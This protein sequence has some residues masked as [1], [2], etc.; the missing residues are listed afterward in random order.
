MEILKI[1]TTIIRKKTI[2]YLNCNG[3][4]LFNK[5]ECFCLSP[6][7]ILASGSKIFC[8]TNFRN[9]NFVVEILLDTGR[10]LA[11]EYWAHSSNLPNKNLSEHTIVVTQGHREHIFPSQLASLRVQ[12]PVMYGRRIKQTSNI[13]YYIY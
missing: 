11:E 10:V 13:N 12:L 1:E 8:L 7:F 9:S 4:R 5:W 3:W 2:L 6:I